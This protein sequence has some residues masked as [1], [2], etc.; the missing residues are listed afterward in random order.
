MRILHFY[1]TSL[2]ASMGGVEQ[3]IH[4]LASGLARRGNHV[5]VLALATS[6]A[7]RE[8]RQMNGYLVHQARLDFEIASNGFSRAVVRRFT[9]LSRHADLI[10]Y[11]YPWPFMDLVHFMVRPSAPT[12]VTYHADIVR[13]RSLLQ[14]YKP[15]RNRF[16]ASVDGLVATSPAYAS[17]SPVLRRFQG[18][19]RVI[20]I[21]MDPLT[22]PVASAALTDDWRRRVGPTFFLF[23]GVLRYY[24]GLHTLLEACR[25]TG[26]P[27]VIAGTGP[28]ERE[29]RRR[30]GQPGLESVHLV[31]YVSDDDKAALLAACRAVVLPSHLRSE[32]FGVTLL[33]SSMSGVPMVTCE[34]GTGTS[35]V[36]LDG[37]TGR[38]VPPGDAD[39]LRG[40]MRELW[41]HPDLAARMGRCARERYGEFFTAERMVEDHLSLYADVRAGAGDNRN[42]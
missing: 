20:P 22:L 35:Y 28:L 32:A 13:Q 42:D 5:D 18:K 23:V 8:T 29:L 36:N 19:T 39:A 7:V 14:L 10:H 38:V 24:K 37:V 30:I 21:G 31:G 27:V 34:I 33:E 15:L 9:E 16:L 25:G 2:P 4:Q 41:E 12:V 6:G 40:A 11:H 3:C 17:S 1:K 26:M